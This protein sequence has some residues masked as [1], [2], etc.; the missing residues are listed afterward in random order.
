MQ[1]FLLKSGLFVA[2]TIGI[3]SATVQA[4]MPHTGGMHSATGHRFTPPPPVPEAP[5]GLD[6][7]DPSGALFPDVR[8]DGTD[9]P[10]A[11][12]PIY[13][14]G[15]IIS[16]GYTAYDQVQSYN[17]EDFLTLAAQHNPTI[18]QS[19]LQISAQTAKALQAGLYP[20]PVLNYV[21]EQIGVDTE[22]DKDS[23]G[24]FQGM[25]LRQRIVTAGKL[26]LS[27]EKYMRRAHVS[28]HLA[29]AQQFRVCN[30]VRIHFYQT[31]AAKEIVELRKELLKSAEDSAVT[32]RELYNQGQ[33]N[34][35]EVHRSNIKL[36]RSRLDVL[37]AEN[38]YRESFR[39]LV[40][41]V[42]VDLTDG[43]VSGDLMPQGPPISYQEAISMVLAES[44]ELAA[45]R[46]KLAADQ[47]TLRREQVEWIPDIV[48]EGGAGYNFDA[49][50][51]VASANVSIELPV[52]DRNQGTIRQAQLDYCRQ[53]EEIRRTEL[54]LQQ[55]MAN[56]YQ[57]YLTALQIAT[58]YERVIV[59]ESE[60][61]YRELLDSYKANR[62]DWP[63]VLDAQMEYF[64]ARLT[65]VQQ[66][67]EVR[68]NEVLVRGYMLQD[69][70]SAAPGPTPPGHIDAVPKPR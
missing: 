45:A 27:R 65:R 44:P 46:A 34:R 36:Q 55:K 49:N 70:L 20:N 35:V 67:E 29:M 32:A 22:D 62:V 17:L 66:L 25:T 68:V 14:D 51:T 23:P 69:G 6:Q 11:P 18:R 63:S 3:L 39:Q 60:L 19:R 43:M 58:E 21:G 54:M 2:S 33:A 40:A 7:L 41:F 1:S 15:Q 56:L 13:V 38:H 24:E 30:D 47:T 53:Q 8:L 48:A 64:D 9:F 31:L 4:Q 16:E 28:E 12:A 10:S 59:P 52:F 37:S 50:E 61:A 57:R 26:R 5:Y 42:G